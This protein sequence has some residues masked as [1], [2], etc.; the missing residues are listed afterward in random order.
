[1]L[2]TAS[3]EKKHIVV[4]CVSHNKLNISVSLLSVDCI[5][6]V[7]NDW[8]THLEGGDGFLVSVD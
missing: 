7:V 8:P 6:V 3:T 4:F 2:S 1:M 5:I